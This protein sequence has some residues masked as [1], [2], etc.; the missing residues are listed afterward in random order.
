M[1]KIV[2]KT[3]IET[4]TGSFEPNR[5]NIISTQINQSIDPIVKTSLLDLNIVP[6]IN[7]EEEVR[8]DVNL[9]DC[10]INMEPS[11][12]CEQIRANGDADADE[13]DD[14]IRLLDLEANLYETSL[15]DNY[16]NLNPIDDDGQQQQQQQQKDVVDGDEEGI[17]FD[18]VPLLSESGL[19]NND[20]QSSLEMDNWERLA[21][22]SIS[23]KV[24]SF[25]IKS[26]GLCLTFAI[27]LSF[28]MMQGRLLVCLFIS[29]YNLI[30]DYFF[31]FCPIY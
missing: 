16:F 29:F 27:L 26:V 30:C 19:I 9:I 1:G 25:Y 17:N 6:N 22:G 24:Y 12:N 23:L 28:F 18:S 7:D 21:F 2:K 13:D 8:D 5:N 31:G 11:A 10:T 20:P 14:D 3:L 15:D 4:P